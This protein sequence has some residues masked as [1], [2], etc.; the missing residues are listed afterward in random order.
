MKKFRLKL[1]GGYRTGFILLLTLFSFINSIY[2]Q[3]VPL[4]VNGKVTDSKGMPLTGVFDEIDYLVIHGY[5]AGD[6][7]KAK[8]QIEKLTWDKKGWPSLPNN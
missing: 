2:A 7:G 6:N 5:D 1:L 3:S 8:L 4:Q